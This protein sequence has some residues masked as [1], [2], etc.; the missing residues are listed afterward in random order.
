[1]DNTKEHLITLN[2][3]SSYDVHYLEDSH[4]INI[5][6]DLQ[7]T[8]NKNILSFEFEEESLNANL[9]K[10]VINIDNI[11]YTRCEIGVKKFDFLAIEVNLKSIKKNILFY[12]PGLIKNKTTNCLYLVITNQSKKLDDYIYCLE[13]DEILGI[14]FE[15]LDGTLHFLDEMTNQVYHSLP[16]NEIIINHNQPFKEEIKVNKNM[17]Y[18]ITKKKYK[19]IIIHIILNYRQ[20]IMY[21]F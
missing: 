9:N 11:Q 2:P 14:P 18:I 21:R 17:K 3:N 8:L 19:V 20:L 10:N 7:Q 6:T 13:K 4:E 12:S 5:D 1:M 15:Y 16:L